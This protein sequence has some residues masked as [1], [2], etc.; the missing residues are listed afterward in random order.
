MGTKICG[1]IEHIPVISEAVNG[2]SLFRVG[3]G[4]FELAPEEVNHG[5]EITS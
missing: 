2:S 3:R 5:D 4:K 1:I